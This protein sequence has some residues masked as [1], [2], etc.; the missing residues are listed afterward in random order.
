[1]NHKVIHRR[2]LWCLYT[3]ILGWAELLT[4]LISVLSLGICEYR[5]DFKLVRYISKRLFEDS[6][7]NIP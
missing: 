1:M 5:L 2:L 6:F 3:W 7:D 4:A